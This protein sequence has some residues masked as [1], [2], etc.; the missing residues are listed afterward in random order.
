MISRKKTTDLPK[1]IQHGINFIKITRNINLVGSS[2][3]KELKYIQDYDLNELINEPITPEHILHLVQQKY[4]R[5][6]KDKTIYISDL[7]VGGHKWTAKDIQ[8]GYVSVDGVEKSLT[9]LLFYKDDL[10]KI[11]LKWTWC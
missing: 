10:F 6:K 5:A 3:I 8:K 11:Y 1:P 2:S 9:D 7:K 4:E